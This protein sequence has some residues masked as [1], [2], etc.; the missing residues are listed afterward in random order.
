MLE[1]RGFYIG[2]VNAACLHLLD[3]GVLWYQNPAFSV[4]M[5]AFY[6][7]HVNAGSLHL[8]DLGVLWYQILHFQL[9]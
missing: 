3:L 9:K 8:L 2:E 6:V 5:R 4:E 1:M 7:G